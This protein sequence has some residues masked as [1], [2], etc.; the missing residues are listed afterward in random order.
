M[1]FIGN[2]IRWVFES[3]E[4]I[5]KETNRFLSGQM[6]FVVVSAWGIYAT[7]MSIY[8][9]AIY[10]DNGWPMGALVTAFQSAVFV[11]LTTPSFISAT[12]S[13][14]NSTLK[15]FGEIE[16]TWLRVTIVVVN[17]MIVLGLAV[18]FLWGCQSTNYLAISTYLQIPS[19]G[20]YQL[21]GLG[22]QHIHRTAILFGSEFFVSWAENTGL[23]YDIRRK[24]FQALENR[25]RGSGN[26]RSASIPQR[27]TAPSQSTI[28]F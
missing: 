15:G 27:P 1:Q 21:F 13:Q 5:L 19:E 23:I 22:G 11:W 17:L 16:N 18:P 28:E 9:V 14:A 10:N 8:C 4:T 25:F 26:T 2:S 7:V 20:N 24:G 6:V 12:I 3:A